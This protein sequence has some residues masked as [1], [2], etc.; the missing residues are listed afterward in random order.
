MLVITKYID[1]A[2]LSPVSTPEDVIKICKEAKKHGFWG[3]DVLPCY[4]PL[5]KK[6]LKGSKVRQI[7]VV[8]YPLGLNTIQEKIFETRQALKM[9]AHEIDMVMNL[10]LFKAK[11]YPEVTKDIKEVLKAAKGRIVKV[12]IE[13]GYLSDAEIMKASKLVKKAGAHFVKTCSGYGPRGVTVKDVK[14][15]RKAVGKF[16]IKASGGIKTAKQA[17]SLI[18]AGATRIGTS[19]GPGIVH[20]LEQS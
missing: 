9:G 11:K 18:E 17:I 5:V 1:A 3:V 19:N 2:L 14:L 10:G 7:G 4:M 15:I 6:E 8:G 13:T 20:E 12:I 16:N